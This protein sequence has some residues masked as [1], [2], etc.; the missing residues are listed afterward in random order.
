MRP[1]RDNAR[2]APGAGETGLDNDRQSTPAPIANQDTVALAAEI[3]AEHQAAQTAAESAVAHAIRAGELLLQ[4]K[5]QLRHG[6]FATWLSH[7]FKFSDRTARAYMQLAGCDTAKRQRVADFSLRDALMQIAD[8]RPQRKPVTTEK[9]LT[10]VKPRDRPLTV[11]CSVATEDLLGPMAAGD[12]VQHVDHDQVVADDGIQVQMLATL[13]DVWDGCTPETRWRF[14][15][16]EIKSIAIAIK[17]G[18]AR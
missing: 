6:S 13:L 17:Q 11:K 18:A 9:T 3:N 14:V 5:K 15:H 4:A 1:R 7:S 8:N 12:H 2:V 16:D 10:A